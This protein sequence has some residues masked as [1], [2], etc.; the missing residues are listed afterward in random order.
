VQEDGGEQDESERPA[1]EEAGGDGDPVEERV[2][3]EPGQGHVPHRR[4]HEGIVMDFLAEVEVRRQGV[5][6]KVHEEIAD[7]HVQV[8]MGHRLQAL[9]DHT[10]ERDGEHEARPQREEVLKKR[11]IP[12]TATGHQG[13][14][15]H[16]GEAGDHPQD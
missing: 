7:Q 15:D 2:N 13:S 4:V 16:V 5:L 3:A 14:A 11:A 1:H 6:R 9:R 8:R 10:Q 12:L